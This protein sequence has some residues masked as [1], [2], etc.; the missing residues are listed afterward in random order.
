MGPHQYL[1]KAID[2]CEGD[3]KQDQNTVSLHHVFKF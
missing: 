3:L 2:C 1:G